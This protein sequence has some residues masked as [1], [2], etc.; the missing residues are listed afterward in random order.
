MNI[1]VRMSSKKKRCTT[2][3]LASLSALN[4][5]NNHEEAELKDPYDICFEFGNRDIGPYAKL[6][7]FDPASINSSRTAISIFL[8]RRLK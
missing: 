7:A 5:Q 6:F 1:F 2:E 8:V 3:T 4:S